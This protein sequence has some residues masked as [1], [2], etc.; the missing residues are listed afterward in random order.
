MCMSAKVAANAGC[1]TVLSKT[2][3]ELASEQAAGYLTEVSQNLEQQR[4]VPC[5]A[6]SECAYRYDN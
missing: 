5:Q 1:C 4:P 3:V 6:S 2:C